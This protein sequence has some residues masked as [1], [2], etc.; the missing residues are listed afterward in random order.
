MTTI[1]LNNLIHGPARPQDRRGGWARRPTASIAAH[2]LL[3]PSLCRADNGQIFCCCRSTPPAGAQALAEPGRSRATPRSNVT[4]L[5]RCRPDRNQPCRERC[6]AP[7]ASRR[8]VRGLARSG[9]ER[10]QP[11]RDRRPV[12]RVGKHRHEAAEAWPGQSGAAG[13]LPPGRNEP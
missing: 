1:P 4:S 12:R 2:G 5:R 8:P 7:N 6:P 13:P 10:Q 11:R 9:G 3:N